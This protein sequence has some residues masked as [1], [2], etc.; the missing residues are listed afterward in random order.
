LV[1]PKNK[2]QLRKKYSFW[3]L[4]GFLDKLTKV[5]TYY[6]DPGQDTDIDE[7]GVPAKY[8]SDAFQYSKYKPF[9]R[10]LRVF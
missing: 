10:G 8:F 9:R 5:F 7:G 4:A 6:F 1:I 3:A 2:N